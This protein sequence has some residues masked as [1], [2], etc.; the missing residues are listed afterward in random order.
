MANMTI[1]AQ[2]RTELGKNANRRL[3][4]RGRIP[5]VVYGRGI[6][7]VSVSVDPK[8]VFRILH[9]ETG[10]NTVFKLKLDERSEDVLIRTFQLDPVNGILLH[11]DFQTISM[12]EVRTFQVPVDVAG[13]AAGVKAGGI[14]DVV[15]REIELECLPREVPEHLQIDVSPLQIGESVRV[16]ELMVD[17]SKI[18]ILSDPDQIILH[19]LAPTIREE[20][21]IEEEEEMA[22]PEVI[23]KG[24]VEEGA[25]EPSE[26]EDESS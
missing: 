2:E 5:G 22:E 25:E 1:E 21:E 11:A 8:E 12:D 4:A 9:S 10:H 13:T 23:K 18:T 17:T 24:R 14:L 19:I 7:P 16:E 6:D 26:A 15:L 3:R 20:E